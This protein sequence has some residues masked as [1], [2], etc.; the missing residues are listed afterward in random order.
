MVLIGSD[1]DLE[2]SDTK[3]VK[4]FIDSMRVEISDLMRAT[5]KDSKSSLE[6]GRQDEDEEG[7]GGGEDGCL[8]FFNISS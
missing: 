1:V 8:R 4:V 2:E 5:S 3:A 7:E 6:L